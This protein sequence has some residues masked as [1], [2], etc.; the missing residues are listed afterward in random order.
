MMEFEWSAPDPAPA[1]RVT[2]LDVSSGE[3][4]VR[5]KPL[6]E[7]R[8]TFDGEPP[9]NPELELR[10]EVLGDAE[11]N[12]EQWRPAGPPVP[13]PVPRPGVRTTALRWP[14]AAPVHRLLV[15][16]R[17]EGRMVLDRAVL[18]SSYPFP[19]TIAPGHDL[20]M[21]VRA[22]RDGE[23]IQEVDWR[24][25]PLEIV[26]GERQAPSPPLDPRAPPGLLFVFTVDTECSVVRQRNPDPDRVVDE[27][28]FGDY[29]TGVPGGI[30]L[31]MDLLE[32]FGFRGCFF[33][34]VLLEHQF[35]QRALERVVEAIA[36]R[37]HEVQLHVHA[38]HLA[39]SSDPALR[40]LTDGLTGEPDRFRRV[41][42]LSV[43][44]F[45]RRTGN[46]PLAYR[47]G[48]YRIAD[49]HF[50]VLEDLGIAV[51]SSLMVYLNAGVKDWMLS[52]TQPFRVGGVLE[53]PV[54]WTLIRDQRR[55]PETRA[56]APN[57]GAGDPVTGIPAP[58]SAAPVV[59][60]FVSH[61]FEMMRFD[62]DP[63][64]AA[65][66]AFERRLRAKVAAEHADRLLDWART[67]MRW[68]DGE[69]D[70][71][72]VS[73][74]AGLLRRVADRP[75]ARCVTYAELHE[76][77]AGL[78]D[79]RRG[80][81]VDPVPA[82]DRRYPLATVSGTRVYSGGLLRRLSRETGGAP[83]PA[84]ADD[85]SSLLGRLDGPW[86]GRRVAVIGPGG[87]SLAPLLARAGARVEQ[88]DEPAPVG[89]ELDA[90]VW[91][92]GF[93]R[94]P[95][96]QLAE[97]LEGLAAMLS[98]DSRALLRVRPLAAPVP[99]E[100]AGLPP[101]A[102]LLFAEAERRANGA[103]EPRQ[104][105]AWD[106]STF[107]AWIASRGLEVVAE[108]RLSRGEADLAAIEGFADKLG[109]L[110]PCE[111]R[112]GAVDLT[113]RR[114]SSRPQSVSGDRQAGSTAV[115][116]VELID[117]LG[118]IRPGDS[119]LAVCSEPESVPWPAAPPEDA[120]LEALEPWAALDPALEPARYDLISW[121]RPLESIGLERLDDACR[122]LYRALRPGGEM[123]VGT[124]RAPGMLATTT[125]ILAALLRGGFEVVETLA[126]R[127]GPDHRL[128][129][130]LS[131]ADVERY[132][133]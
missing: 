31:Q 106:A 45:E 130:P 113:L 36:T 75:D 76:Q 111:L 21:S 121:P 47:A 129:R 83:R 89:A 14:P 12:A 92:V 50:G 102:E 73:S 78:F 46:R 18:G 39:W 100:R 133:R 57:A 108:A 32:H 69:L 28:I 67:R 23:W 34:D 15:Y 49:H 1:Y 93:E 91:P 9:E 104:L 62:R 131:V 97:R 119:V 6:L 25:L 5:T 77:A 96:A 55:A 43:E 94:C 115:S 64:P 22:W 101:L 126:A 95:P 27:L 128:I 66:A 19:R 80:A 110:D 103:T 72:V 81:P 13:V 117:R 107:A 33:V 132:A 30:G 38:E 125:T 86:E 112:V 29:G 82:I 60:T 20:A 70:D 24:P 2:L 17:T 10:L 74:V 3:R 122:A 63:S 65:V 90:I 8:W 116:A 48:G 54:T 11:G 123:L 114:A 87:A 56:F 7:P 127:P 120:S 44:L 105:V 35:G 85:P 71:A 51:D 79:E 68:F 58:P 41:M 42:E 109:A 88:L 40:G 4:L 52:R 37:G 118:G 59:A 53:V 98:D 99:E 26:L 124:A 61:S 84:E 16:D